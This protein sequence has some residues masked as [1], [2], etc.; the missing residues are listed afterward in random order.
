MLCCEDRAEP[1][2]RG[3]SQLDGIRNRVLKPNWNPIIL[4]NQGVG[5]TLLVL[6]RK[7]P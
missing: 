4:L 7:I 3:E 5:A 1:A 6:F 2:G